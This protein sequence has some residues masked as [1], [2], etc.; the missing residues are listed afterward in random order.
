MAG[1]K[2]TS[3]QTD[4]MAKAAVDVD[5]AGQV[6]AGI[7]GRVQQAV[8]ATS[9]GYQSQAAS[10]FR[11]VMDQWNGDFGT[12]ISGLERIHEALTQTQR[13][14]VA[15]ADQDRQSVNQIASLLN[16]GADKVI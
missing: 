8:A 15:S 11:S 5:N 6:L 2:G 4:L 16:G 9:G 13:Q 3:A 14:Y 7:Q 12:I 1:P 10:L